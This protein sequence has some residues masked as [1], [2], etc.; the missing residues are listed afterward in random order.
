MK[1][2][3]RKTVAGPVGAQFRDA[4]GLGS[5]DNTIELSPQTEAA[6]ASRGLEIRQRIGKG[7]YGVVF[8]VRDSNSGQRRAVKVLI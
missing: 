6:L 4:P 8:R 3:N 7:G 2:P 5:S 1:R